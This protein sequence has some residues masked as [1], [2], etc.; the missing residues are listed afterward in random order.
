MLLGAA[1]ILAGEGGFDGGMRCIFQPAQDRGRGALAVLDDGLLVR[2]S[3]EEICG[4]HNWPG[5]AVGRFA[6]TP[7]AL[8][9]AADGRPCGA[10][11]WE[12]TGQP[13]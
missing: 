2:L 6:T 9:A 4:L 11:V 5:L 7:G 1:T 13:R 12:P 8:M 10:P 3:V